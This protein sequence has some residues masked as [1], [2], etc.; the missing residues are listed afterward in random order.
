MLG[1]LA[2]GGEERLRVAALPLPEHHA[3][4]FISAMK[5]VSLAATVR[6]GPC[7]RSGWL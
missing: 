4:G 7:W 1:G 2:R 5:R 3:G 6:R